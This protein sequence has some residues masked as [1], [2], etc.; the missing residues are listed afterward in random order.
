MQLKATACVHLRPTPR[1]DGV[2]RG[3]GRVSPAAGCAAVIREGNQLNPG[4]GGQAMR[5]LR[6]TGL[7][8]WE[9]VNNFREEAVVNKMPALK[10]KV[11]PGIGKGDGRKGRTPRR[12]MGRD[13]SPPAHLPL[14]PPG[15]SEQPGVMALAPSPVSSAGAWAPVLSPPA[16]SHLA[17]T[18]AAPG[19]PACSRPPKH[20][21]PT[22][23]QPHSPTLPRAC[24]TALVPQLR[25]LEKHHLCFPSLPSSRH[26]CPRGQSS[27]CLLS[28][29]FSNTQPPLSLP[30]AIASGELSEERPRQR[31]MNGVVFRKQLQIP[32]GCPARPS[33]GSLPRTS[34]C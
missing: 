11:F 26:L 14:I 28:K 29:C 6:Q 33:A 20:I 12:G 30:P 8:E 13:R 5:L 15:L 7:N 27:P 3:A 21:P 23:P 9:T 16:P 31:K 4:A 32:G 18:G 19:H 25:Q 22:V 10:V 17:G 24:C 2:S 34:A 1:R